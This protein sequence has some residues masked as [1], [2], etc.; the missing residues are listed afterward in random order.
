[1]K[2]KHIE[3]NILLIILMRSI[4]LLFF[5]K[6]SI[7]DIGLGLF[8]GGILIFL[9][10]KLNLKKY[11]IFKILLLFILLYLSITILNNATLFIQDN[12]LKRYSYFLILIPFLALSIYIS[13][14]GYHTYIKTIELSSYILIIMYLL[15]LVLLIPYIKINNYETLNINLSFN[16]I[17]LSFFILII[18]I[19]INYLN[20]YKLNTK[21]YIISSLNI[22]FIKLLIIGILSQTLENI[23]KYS[24]IS[25]YKKI[26]YFDFLER[27]EGFFSLQYLFEYLFLLSLFVLT[28]KFILLNFIPKQKKTN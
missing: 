1:M 12:I 28:I 19:C 18:Y 4:F 22:I 14:K 13:I 3:I 26:S 11:T 5:N 8:L 17:N 21:T 23:F 15:S 2:N 6:L 16:F 24:Y 20:N 9:Y 25:I 27:L 10:Q 7:A